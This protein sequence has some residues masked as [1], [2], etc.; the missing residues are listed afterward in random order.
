MV[1]SLQYKPITCGRKLR[2]TCSKLF[3][4]LAPLF[5]HVKCR[6]TTHPSLL[7]VGVTLWIEQVVHKIRLSNLQ[8]HAHKTWPNYLEFCWESWSEKHWTG[9]LM[10]HGCKCKLK[11][12]YVTAPLP[13][14]VNQS[15][16]DLQADRSIR[17]K[18]RSRA[19]C[20]FQ[21]RSG[22]L[23]EERVP[24]LRRS[25]SEAPLNPPPLLHCLEFV[26]FFHLSYMEQLQSTIESWIILN[27]QDLSIFSWKSISRLML[28]LENHLLLPHRPLQ[29][30]VLK[31]SV[32]Q[33]MP[34]T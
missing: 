11:R 22:R 7:V 5:W 6:R 27:F 18:N 32:V 15:T 30:T 29:K 1:W 28:P 20:S 31:R 13:K 2:D 16:S 8:K 10:F 4:F 25:R 19:F 33:K 9:T 23:F 12:E 17:T 21:C 24:L 3:H 34:C 26:L 14:A